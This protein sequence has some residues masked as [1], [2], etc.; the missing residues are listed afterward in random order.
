VTIK[1]DEATK[2]QF[3]AFTSDPARLAKYTQAA[4]THGFFYALEQARSRGE[5]GPAL[6]AHEYR[7]Y[8]GMLLAKIEEAARE[9]E[10]MRA[11]LNRLERTAE[12]AA[13]KRIVERMFASP[14]DDLFHFK[15]GW[16][17]SSRAT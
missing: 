5:M 12:N 6:F 9:T 16:R 8:Y 17:A 2:A 15:V 1:P 4:M 13:N 7:R 11:A 10:R 3:R 14:E